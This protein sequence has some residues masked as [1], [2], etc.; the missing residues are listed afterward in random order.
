M[1]I[2]TNRYSLTIVI[3]CVASASNTVLQKMKINVEGFV[4]SLGPVGELLWVAPQRLEG[5]GDFL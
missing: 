1:N 4:D 5:R 2:Q 3:S